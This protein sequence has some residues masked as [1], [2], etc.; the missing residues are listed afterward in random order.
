MTKKIVIIFILSIPLLWIGCGSD[1]KENID[2]EDINNVLDDTEGAIKNFNEKSLEG[3]IENISSPVEMAALI[4][5]NGVPFSLRYLSDTEIANELTT[6]FEKALSLGIYGA[7]LGYLNIYNRTASIVGYITAI[8][9]LADDL[10]IG[11]FFDFQTLKRLATNNENLD[12][13]MY[14]STSSFNRMDKYLR[15]NKRG[16]LSA[17]IV[18]GVWIEGIYLATQVEKERHNEKIAERIGEQKLILKELLSILNNYKDDDNFANLIKELN[19][20]KDAYE[21]VTITYVIGEPETV[22]Q[23]G[24]LIIV[25]NETS[26]VNITDEQLQDIIEK[27]EKVRTK[28]TKHNL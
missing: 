24:R 7:D 1:P 19:I 6:D 3:V 9:K 2:T 14:I 13:L 16:N 11:Q 27:V 17:L 4:K 26:V 25:Q 18:S 10:K 12:S 8:K 22:E 28:V 5:E 21:N 20:I 23:D 15:E